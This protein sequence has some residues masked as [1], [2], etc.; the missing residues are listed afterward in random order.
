[1]Q[2]KMC[3]CGMAIL[4]SSTMD[5]TKPYHTP[6]R[7]QFKTIAQCTCAA[8]DATLCLSARYSISLQAAQDIF[9]GCGCKCHR[10]EDWRA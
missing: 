3:T 1:M 7:R 10:V 9:G 8:P 6:R 4:A 5:Y 2:K